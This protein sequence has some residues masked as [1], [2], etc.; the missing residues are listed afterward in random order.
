MTGK[1]AFANFII[2][3]SMVFGGFLLLKIVKGKLE[4]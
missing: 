4:D 1:F 2:I 3:C